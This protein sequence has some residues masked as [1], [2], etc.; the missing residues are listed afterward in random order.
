MEDIL[1][2]V[3]HLI[4]GIKK[5]IDIET[6]LFKFKV[7]EMASAIFS[8]F[9]TAILSLFIMF[10]VIIFLGI[11]LAL[12]IGKWTGGAW[13]GFLIV[14]GIYFIAGLLLWI[15]RDRL[16]RFPVMDLFIKQLFKE[17][18]KDKEQ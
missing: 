18:E 10:L 1:S 5:Y 8:T 16:I 14:A 6:R 12:F 13:A 11:G 15:K 9:F 4:E 3:T 17:N 2:G 7:A